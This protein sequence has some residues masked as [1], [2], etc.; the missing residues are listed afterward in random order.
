MSE[1]SLAIPEAPTQAPETN[2]TPE[3]TIS[4]KITVNPISTPDPPNLSKD[5]HYTEDDSIDN[6]SIGSIEPEAETPKP[7]DIDNSGLHLGQTSHAPD[8]PSGQDNTNGPNGD[9]PS[10]SNPPGQSESPEQRFPPNKSD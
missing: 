3:I 10:Q 2:A 8:N 5:Y 6:I 7:T 9:P 1:T 4:P